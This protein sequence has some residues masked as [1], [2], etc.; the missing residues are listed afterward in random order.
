M[1]TSPWAQK[2]HKL[3]M[4]LLG[5][6][7]F[8]ALV[9]EPAGVIGSIMWSAKAI[10][11]IGGAVGDAAAA[12]DTA[13]DEQAA[14]REQ[15]ALAQQQSPP[16]TPEPEATPVPAPDSDDVGD[17][18]GEL[19][20]SY[21]PNSSPGPHGRHASGGAVLCE[22]GTSVAVCCPHSRTLEEIAACV[23]WWFPPEDALE[24]TTAAHAEINAIVTGVGS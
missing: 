2:R 3:S 16:A 18:D 5:A 7:F 21:E 19:F 11:I 24:Y 12:T 22:A 9:S 4:Y 20:D 13:L 17:G 23:A 10:G 14:E 1:N 15:R 6:V 8:V